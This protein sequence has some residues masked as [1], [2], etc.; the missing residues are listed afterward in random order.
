MP[1]LGISKF[2]NI[3]VLHVKFLNGSFKQINSIEFIYIK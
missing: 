2:T 1:T 3:N